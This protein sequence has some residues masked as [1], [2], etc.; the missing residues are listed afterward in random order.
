MKGAVTIHRAARGL[1]LLAAAALTAGW[2]CAGWAQTLMPEVQVGTRTMIDY[3]FD[4]GRDGVFCQTCNY[5]AGNARLTFIDGDHNVWVGYVDPDTGYFLPTNGQAVLVDANAATAEQIGN[6]PEWMISARGSELVYTRFTDGKPLTYNNLNVGWARMGNGSWIAGPVDGTK[7]QVLPIG[8][9][10][11][12]DPAPFMSYQNFS[13]TSTDVLW[14]IVAS[15]VA[16][17]TIALANPAPGVTRRWIPGYPGM[18]MTYNAPPDA[19]GKVYRQV[20]LY[21]TKTN[22]QTQLTTDAVNKYWAFMFKA[23]EY[24]NEYMFF[25]M[26]G[27]NEIDIYRKVPVN[28]V[29]TWTVINK[30]AMPADMPYVSSPE[31][32]IHNGKTWV[33]FT[34]TST[35]NPRDY[36]TTS[37]VAMTGI[38]PGDNSFRIL[39]SDAITPRVRRDPEYFITSKGPYIYYNAYAPNAQD[40]SISQ[41]VFRVD[42]GL[43][44]P[45]GATTTVVGA[46]NATKH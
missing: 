34:I 42:T 9:M 5:G 22:T 39:T 27:G 15:G 25:V 23:P 1:R 30:I 4:W 12:T 14:T 17:H 10:N 3:E 45:Q 24:N 32:F 21:D 44:P 29:P 31:P 35:S 6:G 13:S 11:V 7:G 8:S 26:V 33:F 46:P 18:I 19:T 38:V 2:A 16:P 28:G 41:G 43:G 37:Q 36:T 20:Y 40:A